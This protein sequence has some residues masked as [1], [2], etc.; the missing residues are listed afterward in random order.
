MFVHMK[1]FQLSEEIQSLL[2]FFDKVGGVDIPFQ[3]LADVRAQKC[4]GVCT[5]YGMVKYI[6]QG[7]GVKPPSQI[8]NYFLCF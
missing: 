2:G 1:L 8:H 7:F 4:K 6:N 5:G 3:M